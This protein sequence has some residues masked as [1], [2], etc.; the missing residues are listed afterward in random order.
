ML[1]GEIL[2][3]DALGSVGFTFGG[4]VMTG[5]AQLDNLERACDAVRL[6]TTR[7]FTMAHARAVAGVTGKALLG[8]RVRQEILCHF[9]VTVAA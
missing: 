3:E 7:R 6:N 4:A 8:M 2:L 5:A 9:G 1:A